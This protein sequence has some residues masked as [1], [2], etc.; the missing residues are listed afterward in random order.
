MLSP[1]VGTD[2][3]VRGNQMSRKIKPNVARAA[4]TII[5]LLTVI[6]IISILVSLLIP[7]VMMA[8][9]SARVTQC[10]NNLR[11]VVLAT[12]AFESDRQRIP[13]LEEVIPC[14]QSRVGETVHSWSVFTRLLNYLQ[15]EAADEL[16]RNKGWS[17]DILGNGPFTLFRPSTYRC[18]NTSDMEIVS[19]GGDPHKIISYAVCWGVWTKGKTERENVFAGLYS[20][21]NQL[22]MHEF[23][24]GISHTIAYSEVLPGVDYFESRF[25][26]TEEIP[27]PIDP[28]A[29]TPGFVTLDSKHHH[30]KSHTQWV[31]ARPVQRASRHG[32]LRTQ[33]S[34]CLATEWITVTG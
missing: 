20:P 18:P 11:Q 7:A 28:P 31:D 17:Q 8:R 9:E 30:Q 34:Q 15:S 27:V 16:K 25:C 32:R 24:D 26:A 33:C 4:F 12:L 29:F 19:A 22:K 6:A 21:R 14:A 23:R 2:F 5:E 10:Q 3:T 13:P 1:L